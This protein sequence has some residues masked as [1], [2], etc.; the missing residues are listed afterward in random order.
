MKKLLFLLS[1]LLLI[2]CSQ[3]NKD[4]AIIIIIDKDPDVKSINGD[5]LGLSHE[6]EQRKMILG[7]PTIGTN[8]IYRQLLKNL[9]DLTKAPISIRISGS[10]TDKQSDYTAEQIIPFQQLFEDGQKEN[11]PLKLIV[12]INL[13]SGKPELASQQAKMIRD[14]LSIDALHSIELGKKPNY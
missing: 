4:E 13:G 3:R 11:I 10:T 9:T 14:N 5:F 12:G 1:V 2:S 6:W 8:S 7:D